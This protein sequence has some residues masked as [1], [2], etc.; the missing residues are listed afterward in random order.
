M[1]PGQGRDIT[2]SFPT[3]NYRM[4]TFGFVRKY[5]SFPASLTPAL[6]LAS[7]RMAPG[8]L[9]AGLHDQRLAL[10]FLQDN[11]AEFGGDPQKVIEVSQNRIKHN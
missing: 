4:N 3:S 2:D 5:F 8:D 7:S 10:T 1:W 6:Q 11:I 9:N